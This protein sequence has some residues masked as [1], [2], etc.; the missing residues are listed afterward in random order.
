MD[1]VH[2]IFVALLMLTSSVLNAQDAT[3]IVRRADLQ[4]RGESSETEMTMLIERPT[5]SR[6]V[7]MKAWSK[8]TDYSLILITAPARD[9]GTTFLKRNKEI[10]NWVPS[11]GRSVKLPPSMMMQSW[12][13]SDF[14]N[15]D[16]V[17]ESSSVT[18]YNHTFVRMDTMD[19]YQVYIIDMIPKPD[20]AVIWGRVRTYIEKDH[21]L[22]LRVEFHD[23]Y[24]DL[25]NV[26][27]GD[28]VK[29][30]DGRLLPSRMVITP[31]DKPGHRTILEYHSMKFDVNIT[32]SFFSIQNMRRVE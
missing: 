24:D 2:W 25:I 7:S 21:Y 18:D 17:R 28:S 1:K 5:W 29:M 11:I 14:T 9:R 10:W 20:A 31:Q 30:F 26:M 6:S 32:E 3:E 13:G 19:E 4:L 16:L 8:G 23:E 12:M 15:D 22:Q 27:Q